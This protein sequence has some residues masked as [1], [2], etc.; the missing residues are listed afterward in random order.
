MLLLKSV[1]PL[2]M[3]HTATSK[4]KMRNATPVSTLL[5][6]HEIWLMCD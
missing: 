5:F 1:T 4:V 2:E 3:I 6:R